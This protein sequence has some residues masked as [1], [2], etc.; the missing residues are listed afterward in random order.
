MPLLLLILS[1][2]FRKNH[3]EYFFLYLNGISV[4][5]VPIYILNFNLK[6]NTNTSL[7][8]QNVPTKRNK[9][10]TCSTIKKNIFR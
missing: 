2:R 4:F 10:V 1:V 5:K 8:I 6:K 7:Q 3:L 9:L